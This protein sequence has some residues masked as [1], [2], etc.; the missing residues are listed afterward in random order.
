MLKLRKSTPTGQSST[1]GLIS[2]RLY[3]KS[4]ASIYTISKSAETERRT[5]NMQIPNIMKDLNTRLEV[6]VY[7]KNDRNI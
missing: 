1:D 3:V 6:D 2:E 7:Q 4:L 5:E